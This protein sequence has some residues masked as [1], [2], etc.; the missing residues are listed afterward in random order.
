MGTG[1]RELGRGYRMSKAGIEKA[2]KADA[3]RK[4]KKEIEA[5]FLAFLRT[6]EGERVLRLGEEARKVSGI[7]TRNYE[8]NALCTVL[9]DYSL[10]NKDRPSLGKLLSEE[11]KKNEVME[12]DI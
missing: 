7:Q 11:E 12:L 6:E 5:A 8:L 2:K 3:E 10:R 4:V 9:R 1:C